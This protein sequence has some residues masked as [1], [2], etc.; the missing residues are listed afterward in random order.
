MSDNHVSAVA[1]FQEHLEA[2]IEAIEAK[3]KQ[4]SRPTSDSW[5]DLIKNFEAKPD[6][7]HNIVQAVD[8]DGNTEWRVR[9]SYLLTHVIGIAPERVTAVHQRRLATV[10]RNLG[11]TGPRNLRFGREQAKGYFKAEED[12]SP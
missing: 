5:E 3:Q 4:S 8:A 11:W 6:A 1:R 2:A 9:S 7:R 12:V 10:M